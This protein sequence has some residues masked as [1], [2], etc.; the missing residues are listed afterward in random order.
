[1]SRSTK[2]WFARDADALE[3]VLPVP[4]DRR[5]D[6]C[7]RCGNLIGHGWIRGYA[8]DGS[9][10]GVR[11]RRLLCTARSRRGCGRTMSV[12]LATVVRGFVARTSTLFA[13]LVALEAGQSIRSSR[14]ASSDGLT[15]RTAY[16]LAARLRSALASL[17]SRLVAFAD[18]PAS[19]CRDP[20]AALA[21]HLRSGFPDAEDPL[22]ALQQ[23]T[24]R[25]L[26]RGG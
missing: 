22:A 23:A 20:I 16:R 15:L 21:A 14:R 13:L 25:G 26:F 8:G 10:D 18:P 3:Q 2:E 7:G 9:P 12:W 11:G 24:G 1:M 5:C 19:S 17:R 6:A 4:H